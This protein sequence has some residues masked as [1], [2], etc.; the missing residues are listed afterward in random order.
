MLYRVR[1]YVKCLLCLALALFL[2][3][4]LSSNAWANT[5]VVKY[6]QINPHSNWINYYITGISVPQGFEPVYCEYPSI[7]ILNPDTGEVKYKSNDDAQWHG[8]S[9]PQVP[10]PGGF[11]PIC[12]QSS[13]IW[14]IN[15]TNGVLKW[16]IL[17]NYEW[18]NY[19]TNI[20][21][22]PSGFEPLYCAYN[23]IYIVNPATGMIKYKCFDDTQWYDLGYPF[24]PLPFPS[25]F[26]PVYYDGNIY[27][28][29]ANDPATLS[30]DNPIND[31][32]YNQGDII[33][34]SGTVNDVDVGD[35]IQV[36][37]TI[38]G[39]AEHQN[40]GVA[41]LTA[42]GTNQA[43]SST[44][45]VDNT[46]PE[47][48]QTIRVWAES[49]YSNT[50][51]EET[52]TL[53]IDKTVAEPA[54]RT[55]TCEEAAYNV[56]FPGNFSNETEDF[57]FD[58]YGPSKP[59]FHRSYNNTLY[60]S[61]CT[62]YD[63]GSTSA[64]LGNNIIRVVTSEG[65]AF[66]VNKDTGA[67]T[68]ITE[69][70]LQ[71]NIG[72]GKPF[73]HKEY[74]QTIGGFGPFVF[75][76]FGTTMAYIGNNT[77]RVVTSEGKA[78]DVNKDTGDYTEVTGTFLVNNWGS[79]KPF[80]LREYTNNIRG[81]QCTFYDFGSTMA[82]IGNDILRVVTSEGK[83]FDVDVNDGS[84]TEVTTSFLINNYGAGK[85]F[86]NHVYDVNIYGTN[87]TF[88]DFGTTISYIDTPALE[89][90]VFSPEK[91]IAFETLELTGKVYD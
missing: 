85:P 91:I 41:T 44:I 74:E 80:Y 6:R 28:M 54:L 15:P 73:Y 5:G 37:Y 79:G 61:Q 7:C 20:V 32:S 50:S 49:D 23:G 67:Y 47:G 10:L 90:T 8:L 84:Y 62:F 12:I 63:F 30:L 29:H 87:Y 33:T 24:I 35:T 27:I 1:P 22:I 66:D 42:D 40:V 21:P 18:M 16:R 51:A 59:F 65:K 34:V 38:D 36:K 53:I 26:V 48:Q 19:S 13:Y 71:D 55:V 56:D 57:L 70:F 76:D 69:D 86:Y 4:S 9:Y 82:Y 68:E 17:S 75:H 58:N 25:G 39:L 83:A 89:L 43:F 77:L 46:I 2:L 45:T 64:Y 78:F 14:I 81:S 11:E 3:L 60:N 31:Q 52:R 88:Y 72:T